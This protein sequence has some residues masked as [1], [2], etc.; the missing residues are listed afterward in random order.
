M[1]LYMG[2]MIVAK[3][4]LFGY[5][6]MSNQAL[7]RPVAGS[8][9]FAPWVDGNMTMDAYMWVT[10]DNSDYQFVRLHNGSGALYDE[11]I[12]ITTDKFSTEAQ[13]ITKLL[14]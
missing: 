7:M 11:I 8:H 2:G 1:K 13:S 9:D 14:L 12:P 6:Y 4:G 5:N 3:E 10:Y